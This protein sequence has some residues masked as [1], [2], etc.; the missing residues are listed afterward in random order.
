MTESDQS[1]EQKTQ[2]EFHAPG[3]LTWFGQHNESFERA[4]IIG[5][6]SSSQQPVR[7]SSLKFHEPVS[8]LSSSS[9]VNTRKTRKTHKTRK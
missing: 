3:H 5:F 6:L 1:V 9:T 8:R 7:N 2:N 4:K